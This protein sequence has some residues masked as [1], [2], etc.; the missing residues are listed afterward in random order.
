[1]TDRPAELLAG[2]GVL[3]GRL[4]GALRQSERDRRG[5]QALAVVGGHQ[6]LE[7]ARGEEVLA[8]D[9]ATVEDDLPFGDAAHPHRALAPCD[10]QTGVPASTISA[11]IP[12]DPDGVEPA[13]H[14]VGLRDPRARDPALGSAEHPRIAG[15]LGVRLSSEAAEPAPGSVMAIAGLSPWSTRGRYFCFWASRP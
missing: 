10:P 14:H 6:L 3:H 7:A 8:G 12:A 11:P 1:M 2:A 9:P 13:Q 5:A 15:P 4:E